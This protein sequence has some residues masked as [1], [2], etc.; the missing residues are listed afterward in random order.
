MNNEQISNQ[1]LFFE[2]RYWLNK[3]YDVEQ[4]E[5]LPK[6]FDI[7]EIEE[8]KYEKGVVRNQIDIKIL[9][10]LDKISRSSY[11]AMFSILMAA[12]NI[13]LYK[14]DYR[15]K[16]DI[17]TV[18]PT[19]KSQ[20]N[21]L[22][23]IV[24]NNV[25]INGEL[26]FKELIVKVNKSLNE[27]YQYSNYPFLNLVNEIEKIDKDN[28]DVGVVFQN[29]QDINLITDIKPNI[30]FDFIITEH[31]IKVEGIYNKVFYRHDTIEKYLTNICNVLNYIIDDIEIKVSEIDIMC[32]EEKDKII[33]KFNDTKIELSEGTTIQELFY[34][35]VKNHSKDIA[36]IFKDENISYGELNEKSNKLA[37][38]LRKK[39][40]ARNTIIGLMTDRSPDMVIGMLGILKAGGAYLPIDPEYPKSRIDYIIK[41]S[42]LKYIV[43]NK[44][45]ISKLNEE[46]E[47]I[48]IQD[49]SISEIEGS[50]VSLINEE[51][52]LAYVIYTSGSTGN[53][54]GVMI[55][56]CGI[57]NFIMWSI[58]ELKFTQEDI[59]LQLISFTFDGFASNLYSGILSGG[60]V[61]IVDEKAAMNFSYIRSLINE[62]KVTNMSIVPSMY[63]A[64]L[65]KC[66][67][68]D[69]SSLRFVVLAGDRTQQN[70]IEHSED[71]N[72]KIRLINCYGPT[73]N[74]V[75]TSAYF[76]MKA[77]EK[78]YIGKPIYNNRLYVLSENGS[79]M[80]KGAIGELC[81]SG[82][83][84]ARGYLNKIELT[85]E[86]FVENPLENG[87]KMYKTG[88][89]VRWVNDG[90]IEYIDRIDDQIKIR[91]LRIESGEIEQKL[92][93]HESIDECVVIKKDDL[94]GNDVLCA[95]IVPMNVNTELNTNELRSFLLKF[96]PDYM[97]PSYFVV[98]NELPLMPNGKLDK[99]QLPNPKRNIK[100]GNE[101]IAPKNKVQKKLVEILS[102]TIGINKEKIGIKDTFFELG[103][104]SMIMIQLVSEINDEF[105]SEIK[106]T[107]LFNYTT[108]EA[109]DKLISDNKM[110]ESDV[111]KFEI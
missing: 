22:N 95:Y 16:K 111:I 73:E 104:N 59:T 90:D 64:L 93:M 99:K 76:G 62:K 50:D 58:N 48:D 63:N 92:L 4:Q 33:K 42:D 106:V 40:V 7:G 26:T 56:H 98:L 49:K 51:N 43:G 29:I 70:I 17:V 69:L 41:D 20:E 57:V 15:L 23:N 74:S 67:K 82:R 11:K 109:L 79:L 47:C 9:N 36:I 31:T 110:E 96:L 2:K 94:N 107:D 44:N 66:K 27:I 83:G 37:R 21:N 75:T 34:K 78:I 101:Y 88:D 108:V 53:P 91:G 1:Q 86:K 84:I 80:P 60:S 97:I 46:I 6:D 100:T 19:I 12:V 85:K 89:M 13:V 28:I 65:S 54:K 38:Y 35:Q 25:D 18:I 55:E 39:S 81:V 68:G 10:K 102:N 3:L 24:I 61:L 30:I 105:K 72:S 5:Q 45:L 32:E 71:I 103:G 14:Y 87:N 8:K 52:D 77:K